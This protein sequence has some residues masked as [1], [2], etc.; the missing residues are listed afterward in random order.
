V[1]GGLTR[2]SRNLDASFEELVDKKVA[3][4]IASQNLDAGSL[5]GTSRVG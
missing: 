3:E 4:K 1:S 5:E 2:T